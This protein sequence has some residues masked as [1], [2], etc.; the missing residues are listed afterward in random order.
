MKY[1]IFGL[2]V[3]VLGRVYCIAEY[4]NTAYRIKLLQ[5]YR[6]ILM[7][8]EIHLTENMNVYLRAGI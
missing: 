2:T 1:S 7:N 6:L 5:R 8:K 4:T 3:I